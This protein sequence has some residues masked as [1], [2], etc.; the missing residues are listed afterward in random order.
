MKRLA[1]LAAILVAGCGK[2]SGPAAPTSS[3]PTTPQATAESPRAA[4]DRILAEAEKERTPALYQ[5]AVE[6]FDQAL[7][8][9]E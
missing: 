8:A 9:N 1:L 3:T 4:A 2:E 7:A 5:E 6:K